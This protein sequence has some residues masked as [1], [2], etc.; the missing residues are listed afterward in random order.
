M[1]VC[2]LD[3]NNDSNG[4]RPT[5]WNYLWALPCSILGLTI[6]LIFVPFGIC[7]RTQS[8]VLEVFPR[9]EPIPWRLP[10]LAITFGHVVL[11]KNAGCLDTLRAHEMVHV[12]QY[13]LWGVFF[14][15]AYPM[16]SL[17]ALFR[18]KNPY[19][20]NWFEVEARRLSGETN[21]V[22]NKSN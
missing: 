15:L 21:V 4:H 2:N 12:R 11:G 22:T 3:K 19:W 8:G 9:R 14:L 6:A 10:F 1:A 17:F 7:T 16:A 5:I 20:F 18:G 13:E